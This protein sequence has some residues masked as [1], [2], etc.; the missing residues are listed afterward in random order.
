M[1]RSEA[2]PVPSEEDSTETTN[3]PYDNLLVLP[4]YPFL[5]ESLYLANSFVGVLVDADAAE[6][7]T[8]GY[9]QYLAY[10]KIVKD[11]IFDT[12]TAG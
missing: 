4:L 10:R 9:A 2:N 1:V 12:S 5:T 6:N 8:A 7:A 11:A 3:T